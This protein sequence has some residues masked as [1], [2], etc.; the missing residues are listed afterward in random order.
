MDAYA[1]TSG[2]Q[3]VM[4]KKEETTRGPGG[5]ETGEQQ[6]PRGGTHPGGTATKLSYDRPNLITLG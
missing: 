6:A 1:E 2:E 5:Q 4:A 3:R